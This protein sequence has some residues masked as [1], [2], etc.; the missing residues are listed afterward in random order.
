VSVF[1]IFPR[2]RS[3]S[4]P[5]VIRLVIVIPF[6]AVVGSQSPGSPPG[7]APRTPPEHTPS[8]LREKSRLL[9]SDEVVALL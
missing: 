2:W 9:E 1:L 7:N 5:P 4:L 8:V 3:T 6:H